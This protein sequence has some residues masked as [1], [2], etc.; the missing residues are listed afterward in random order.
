[1]L[2]T[3]PPAG[4]NTA[5]TEDDA[6]DPTTAA[7]PVRELWRLYA[8]LRDL[9]LRASP[10]DASMY[11]DNRFGHLLTDLSKAAFDALVADVKAFQKELAA[12]VPSGVA[13]LPES[14]HGNYAFLSEMVD[15]TLKK[16]GASSA[17]KCPRTSSSGPISSSS[18]S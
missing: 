15:L 9:L 8:K 16:L 6:P 10:S 18:P 4:S 5:S 7:E 13:A 12:A 2:V 11:G 3:L 17:T 14:E 1:M